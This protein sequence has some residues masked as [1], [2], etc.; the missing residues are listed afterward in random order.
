MDWGFAVL[1]SR[2]YTPSFFLE[3]AVS[4]AGCSIQEPGDSTVAEG[5][6]LR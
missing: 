5:G 6:E 2:G 3:T 1:C 4:G